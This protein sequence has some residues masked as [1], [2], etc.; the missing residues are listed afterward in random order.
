VEGDQR[1][2]VIVRKQ[3]GEDWEVVKTVEGP[4]PYLIRFFS[5][6]TDPLTGSVYAGGFYYGE[7]DE[8]LVLKSNQ[9]GDPGTWVIEE[10]FTRG[11]FTSCR[12]LA[13]DV[14]GNVFAS[15]QTRYGEWLVRKGT[16]RQDGTLIWDDLHPPGKSWTPSVA[17]SYHRTTGAVFLGGISEE[18]RWTIMRSLNGGQTWANVDTFTPPGE[19]GATIRAIHSDGKNTI[20]AVGTIR[21]EVTP[22][23]GGQGKNASPGEY[24]DY[25]VVRKSQ[26]H[27]QTWETLDWHNEP[28]ASWRANAIATDQDG[29]V[30]VAVDNDAEELWLIRKLRPQSSSW[31]ISDQLLPN[32]QQLKFI[33]GGLTVDEQGTAYAVGAYQNPAGAGQWLIRALPMIRGGIQGMVESEGEPIANAVVTLD[34]GLAVVTNDE[35]VF[36]FP[37]LPVGKYNVTASAPGFY[38]ETEP[39]VTVMENKTT[40]VTFSLTPLPAHPAPLLVGVASITHRTFG[41]RHNTDNVEVIMTVEDEWETLVPGAQVSVTVLRNGSFFASSTAV[42]DATGEARFVLQKPPKGT[43]T[44]MATNL[45]VEG[46]EWD[47]VQGS[48]TFTR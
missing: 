28:G 3:P 30:Y 25:L 19:S 1:A 12:N 22:P 13:V 14:D 40:E 10:R 48:H 35:G 29:T 15:G 26:D 24:K 45:A 9:Q 41:G 7:E 33:L 42:S 20:Y 21:V 17:L 39:A 23:S 18:A 16:R 47:G 46:M 44:V 38:P 31:E 43:Y 36:S 4:P 34:G 32:E 37:S 11:F 6:A 27:G 2:G 8:W 5:V